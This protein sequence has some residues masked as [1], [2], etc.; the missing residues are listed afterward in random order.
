[1]RENSLTIVDL[2]GAVTIT[3]LALHFELDLRV[4][5]LILDDAEGGH[6]RVE[7]IDVEQRHLVVAIVDS[8]PAVELIERLAA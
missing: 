8:R 1:M 5:D 2:D 4:G 3:R 7:E 6:W